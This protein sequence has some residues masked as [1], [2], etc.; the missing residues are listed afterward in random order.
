MVYASGLR[1]LAAVAV[2]EAHDVVLAEVRPRLYLDD[3]EHDG[4]RILDAMLHADRDVSRLVLLE[5]EHLLAAGDARRACDDHPVLGPMMMHLQRELRTGLDLQAL[6]LKARSRFDAVVASP[7]TEYLTVERVLV[8]PAL[9]QL[10]HELLHVL[11]SV[12]RRH[13]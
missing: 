11:H 13:H 5:E 3:L 2:L 8:T 7:G 4:A 1:A 12:L 9:F 10:Q 6:H